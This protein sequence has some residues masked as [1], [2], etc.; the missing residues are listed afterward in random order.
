MNHL[1]LYTII[2]HLIKLLFGF[3]I[4]YIVASLIESWM[5]QYVS[6][7]PMR[8]V[9]KWLKYP[10]LLNYLIRTNYSHHV[11]HHRKTFKLNHITQFRNDKER[12]CLDAELLLHGK[13]GVIIKKSQYA[14]KLHGS[15]SLVFIAPLLPVAILF[16]LL[17]GV[18]ATIG[19]IIALLCPPLLSNYI[20]PY[21]HMPHKQAVAESPFIISWLLKKS[22]FKAM[23]RNHFMHHKYVASNFNQLLESRI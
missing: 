19:A 14:V 22:Y 1:F 21:L 4:G 12:Y 11:V 9:N 6:D 20:H 5:H 7:A 8:L 10:R 16:P 2:I 17:L 23:A 13:H 3:I 18:D 15:G